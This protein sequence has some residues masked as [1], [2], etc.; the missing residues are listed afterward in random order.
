MICYMWG[1]TMPTETDTSSAASTAGSTT[2]STATQDAPLLAGAHTSSDTAKTGDQK[3]ESQTDP[4]KNADG[5]AKTPEQITA[6]KKVT[7]DKTAADKKTADEKAKAVG[8]PEKYADL[9]LPEGV[10]F[11]P[12]STELLHAFGK[13]NNLPQEA[14]QK[15]ADLAVKHN[16]A[17]DAA[18]EKQWADA[19]TAWKAEI[20]ADP[21]IGGSKFQQSK[22]FAI[23]AIQQFGTAELDQ[24]F[25]TGWG[26]N[27]ALFKFCVNVGKKISESKIV[28]GSPATETKSNAS[29]FYPNHK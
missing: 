25:K 12:E 9:K 21:E 7:D 13:E 2:T 11:A 17:G 28:E 16:Q 5:T 8:A 3:T 26:D 22:E 27:P 23:R 6:D 1:I 29:T 14:V 4:T 20:Q 24:V 18:R 10:T 19:R 15:L